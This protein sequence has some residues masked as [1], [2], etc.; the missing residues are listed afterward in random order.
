MNNKFTLPKYILNEGNVYK[1]FIL[2]F[3]SA[4]GKFEWNKRK[5][6]KIGN[7]GL[8][9]AVTVLSNYYFCMVQTTV[10]SLKQKPF[11]CLPFPFP[12]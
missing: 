5:H 4:K 1:C 10:S 9:S 2:G 8:S 11:S 3:P 7:L 6:F 12:S